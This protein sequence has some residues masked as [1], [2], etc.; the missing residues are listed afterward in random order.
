M[1][2]KRIRNTELIVE[3]NRKRS[4]SRKNKRR[5]GEMWKDERLLGIRGKWRKV[6]GKWYI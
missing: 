3:S 2:C 4:V 5:M 1:E 6:A